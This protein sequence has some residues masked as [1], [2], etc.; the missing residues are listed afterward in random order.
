MP[1]EAPANTLQRTL[2]SRTVIAMVVGGII[3][4]GIFMKPSLMLQQLGS[5]WLL[6]SVWVVAGL[7]TMFGSL[8]NSEVAAMFPETG[9]QYVFFQKMYGNGFAFLYGWAAFAV[10]NT[11]GNASI[12]Y[13]FSEY[14]NY[15]L[16]MPRF[17]DATERS[18]RLYIPYIGYVFPLA[19]FGVKMLTI[20]LIAF[21]TLINIR[22]VA[23]TGS[24]Q[25]ILTAMK[26]IAI[27]LL[28]AGI[29]GS[30]NGSFSHLSES[31]TR[32][33]SL[34]FTGAYV[35]AL[36]GAFWAYDGWNN[37]MFVAGEVQEPQ[38]NIP[39]GLFIGVTACIIIYSLI[40]L[41]YLYALP[42]K[43]MAASTFVAADA[44]TAIWGAVG[45]GLIAL[46]V[47]LSTVGA[48]NANVFSTSRVTYAMGQENSLF[49]WAGKTNRRYRTPGNALVLNAVWASLMVIT[50]SFDMLTDMLVFVSWFFYGM[51]ALGLFILRHKYADM[52]RV[53]RV[54]GYPFVPGIFVAFT[55]FFLAT[56]LYQDISNYNEGKIPIIN[57]LLGVLITCAG[58]PVYWLSKRR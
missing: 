49:A 9:G 10:F 7:L 44:A 25:R 34:S 58:L 52:P 51:T 56:T 38:K 14:A 21:F 2:N 29:F 24:L 5:P 6:I 11:A 54:P 57:S 31:I 39:R 27:F 45:G 41:S 36:A 28:I 40:N 8:S 37:I 30:G 3:G 22:S 19:N 32:N 35:A 20:A 50:G 13:V 4:S 18:V 1:K 53:F 17:S 12:A 15:F 23:V 55:A 47:M 42:V 16:H 48:A 33:E 46:M 26:A 43:E